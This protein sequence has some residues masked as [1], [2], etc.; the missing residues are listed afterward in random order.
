MRKVKKILTIFFFILLISG[1][2]ASGVVD[3]A[4]NLGT[5]FFDLLHKEIPSLMSKYKI[6]GVIIAVI[7]NG[8]VAFSNAYG[9]ANIE[10][11]RKMSINDYCRVESIS[12]SLTVAKSPP[13]AFSV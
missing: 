1:T 4:D 9:F 11:G 6:P 3:T 8:E 13:E 5:E 7:K 10:T 12:K 2:T